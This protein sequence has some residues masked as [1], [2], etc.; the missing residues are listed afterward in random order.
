MS[1][2]QTEKPILADEMLGKSEEFVIRY[3]KAIIGGIAAIVVCVLGFILYSKYVSEPQETAANNAI[4]KAQQYFEQ[5]DFETA[6][7][8]DGV[9]AG[10]LKVIEEHSGTNAG[11]LAYAYAG[12]CQAQMGN[13]DE[14]IK[15]LEEFDSNDKILGPKAMH[16]LAMCYAHKEN[17]DKARSL[18]LDAAEKAE[19]S[20]ITP[21]CWMDAAANYEQQGKGAEAKKLY[22]R[23]KKEYPQSPEAINIDKFINSV[24]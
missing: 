2:K 4:F 7:N 20:A 18:L 22:E 6:L 19:N 21:R 16:A 24:N 9:N 3:K 14:A 10:F 8:S 1:K 11:N 15:N 17:L 13:Y 5:N 12:F 23:V